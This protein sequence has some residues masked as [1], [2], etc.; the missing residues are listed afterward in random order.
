MY[1]AADVFSAMDVAKLLVASNAIPDRMETGTQNHEGIVGAMAAVNFLASLSPGENRRERIVRTMAE[2][3]QR[4]DVLLIQM[5]EGLSAIDG[6]TCYGPA[7]GMPRTPTISFRVQGVSPQEVA[8]RLADEG[9]FVSNGS[10][11]ATGVMERLGFTDDGLVRAGCACYT[12]EADVDRLI[13]G[14]RKIANP[15]TALPCPPLGV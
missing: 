7:P 10:F 1:A 9:V 2:L 12:T 13:E 15:A 5:W 8:R 4:G 6:I 11:Y 3:H 14:V